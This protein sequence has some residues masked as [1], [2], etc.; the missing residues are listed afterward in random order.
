MSETAASPPM[1]ARMSSTLV[2]TKVMKIARLKSKRG[3]RG[4]GAAAGAAHGP[5]HRRAL[6]AVEEFAEA[7]RVVLFAEGAGGR[8]GGV[9]SWRVRGRG[10]A[11]LSAACGHGMKQAW[12][13]CACRHAPRAA[14][15]SSWRDAD[16]DTHWSETNGERGHIM[17]E[18]NALACTDGRGG[19]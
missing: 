3:G 6:R 17:C 5:S 4:A 13:R 9:R 11:L 15:R 19:G 8:G 7:A 14:R 12:S 10:P 2:T 18:T 1:K 16:A